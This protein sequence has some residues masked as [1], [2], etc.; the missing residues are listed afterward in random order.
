MQA[1]LDDMAQYVREK[2]KKIRLTPETVSFREEIKERILRSAEGNF[3]WARLVIE[4]VLQCKRR[5]ETETALKELTSELESLY[6]RMEETLSSTLMHSD[7]LALVKMIFMWAI[8]S[9]RHLTTQELSEALPPDASSVLD[10]PSYIDQVCGGFVVVDSN[11]FRVTLST[12]P[13]NII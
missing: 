10:L 11:T 3:L 1:D 7:D 6:Q 4:R 13:R 12:T 2:V 9:K 5:S 8:C